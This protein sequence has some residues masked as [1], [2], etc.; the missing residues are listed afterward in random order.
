MFDD[1]PAEIKERYL[2]KRAEAAFSKWPGDTIFGV[3]YQ[4]QAERSARGDVP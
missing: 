2:S 1:L 4:Q 3:T